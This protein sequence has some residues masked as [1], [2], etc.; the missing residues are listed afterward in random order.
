MSGEAEAG[1]E[2]VLH[3]FRQAHQGPLLVK[4]IVR[5]GLLVLALIDHVRQVGRLELGQTIFNHVSV[6]HKSIVWR[7]C[8][9]NRLRDRAF[10]HIPHSQLFICGA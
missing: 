9:R 4:H 2:I 10:F 7:P 8:E 3:S 1:R 6:L 5:I